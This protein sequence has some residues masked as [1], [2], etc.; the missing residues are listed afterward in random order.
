MSRARGGYRAGRAGC[1]VGALVALAWLAASG[2]LRA[3]P[4][5]AGSRIVVVTDDRSAPEAGRLIAELEALGFEVRIVAPDPDAEDVPARLAQT[6]RRE[7]ALAAIRMI[8]KQPSS[9]EVWLADRA[10]NKTVLREVLTADPRRGDSASSDEESRAREE[11]AVRAVELLRASLLETESPRGAKGEVLPGDAAKELA[12]SGLPLPPAPSPPSQRPPLPVRPPALPPLPLGHAF[13]DFGI[14]AGVGALFALSDYIQPAFALSLDLRYMPSKRIGV[15]LGGFIPLVQPSYAVV[16]G[17]VDVS[18]GWIG[19]AARFEVGPEDGP[20]GAALEPGVG[21]G[22]FRV[23]GEPFEAPLATS[24]SLTYFAAIHARGAF[25]VE[26]APHF[27]LR[28]DT[29]VG[30]A[31]P[32]KILSY[33]T[34]SGTTFAAYAAASGGLETTF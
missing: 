4:N 6:T 25:S 26:I 23:Q 28:A 5:P 32:G 27:A 12:R 8:R 3:Q 31:L 33:P 1:A 18:Y 34:E 16:D 30:V 29:L 19:P 9:I 24:D 20:F 14:H 10:T 17:L 13:R 2:S 7:D 15:A 21:L 11:V 22:W